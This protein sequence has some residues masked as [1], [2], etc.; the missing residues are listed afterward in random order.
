MLFRI[1]PNW[2]IFNPFRITSANKIHERT[3]LFI[4]S[5]DSQQAEVACVP[6]WTQWLERG[7]ATNLK[8]SSTYMYPSMLQWTNRS[9]EGVEHWTRS[10]RNTTA[11][12]VTRHRSPD[13]HQQ[14]K[15]LVYSVNLYN[16]L[17]INQYTWPNSIHLAQVFP[18]ETLFVMLKFFQMVI[19]CK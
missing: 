16:L 13:R 12:Q 18:M 3:T 7:H 14:S 2:G 5:K 1:L 9:D 10:T 6:D 19:C 15:T 11:H 4:S 17:L 8:I